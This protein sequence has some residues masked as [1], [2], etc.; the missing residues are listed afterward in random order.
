MHLCPW[1]IKVFLAYYAS[2]YRYVDN[3]KVAAYGRKVRGVEAVVLRQGRKDAYDVSAD[4]TRLP[5]GP[6]V[7]NDH[8]HIVLAERRRV[9][10]RTLLFQIHSDVF[11]AS[12]YIL[13]TILG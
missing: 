13:R 2:R 7:Q 11:N 9:I 5:A 8:L 1:I 12:Y 4:E 3:Y 6:A 10:M